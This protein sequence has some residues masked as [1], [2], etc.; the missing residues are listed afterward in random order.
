[1]QALPA[2]GNRN[3]A[4]FC[5]ADKNDEL[6]TRSRIVDLES[7]Y[8]ILHNFLGLAL[9]GERCRTILSETMQCTSILL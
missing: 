9:F 3:R 5:D 8:S 4:A 2:R 7:D 6:I 1:M